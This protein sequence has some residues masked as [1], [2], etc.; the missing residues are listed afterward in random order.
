MR[1]LPYNKERAS[2]ALGNFRRGDVGELPGR[3]TPQRIISLIALAEL[4]PEEASA[5]RKKL[6]VS[7]RGRKL[8]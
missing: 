6:G 3:I 2:E 5:L 1:V 8:T 7:R 4:S